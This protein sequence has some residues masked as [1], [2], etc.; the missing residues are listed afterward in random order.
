[1]KIQQKDDWLFINQEEGIHQTAR[2]AGALTLD[3]TAPDNMRE[4]PHFSLSVLLS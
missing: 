3:F 4:K 1:M 2:P